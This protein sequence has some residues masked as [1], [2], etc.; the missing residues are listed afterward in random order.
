MLKQIISQLDKR[1][2]DVNNMSIHL[3]L[4]DDLNEI[5]NRDDIDSADYNYDLKNVINDV[6]QYRITNS[7]LLDYY[8]YI[9]NSDSVIAN[10]SLYSNDLF[11]KRV[12]NYNELSYDEW[13]ELLNKPY[14]GDI[15]EASTSKVLKD[16]TLVFDETNVV[17]YMRSIPI[18]FS[19]YAKGTVIVLVDEEDIQKYFNKIVNND[20]SWGYIADNNGNIITSVND[21]SKSFKIM[22]KNIEGNEGFIEDHSV[23]DN[24][25]VSYAVS[26]YNDWVYV[27]GVSTDV[28]MANL[29][30]IKK[31]TILIVVLDLLIGLII[32]M[33]FAY[34]NSKPVKK[35][36][37]MVKDFFDVNDKVDNLEDLSGSVLKLIDNNMILKESLNK[38][39]PILRQTF[40][41]RLLNSKFNNLDEIKAIMSYTGIK[42]EAQNYIVVIMHYYDNDELIDE[43]VVKEFDIVKLILKESINSLLGDKGLS[44]DID[45]RKIAL[46]IY[47][48]TDDEK[49]C[50]NNTK[51]IIDSICK[52][53]DNQYNIKLFFSIGSIYNDL[54]SL[55][56]SYKE[57]VEVM[58]IN[59][60]YK[61]N[62]LFYQEVKNDLKPYYFPIDI[63]VKLI[64]YV[65]AGRYQ[66]VNDI[67]DLMYDENFV[68]RHLHPN[69]LKIFINQLI[70]TLIRIENSLEIVVSDFDDLQSSGNNLD[71]IVAMDKRYKN[72]LKSYI[73]I[74]KI[75]DDKKSNKNKVL[76]KD[77][78]SFIKQNYNDPN[79]SLGAV[80]NHFNLT[81]GYLSHFIKDQIEV[82]FLSYIE[83]IRM[84]SA[85]DFLV[86]TEYSITE[87]SKMVGY[88]TPQA[89]RRAFKR[90]L[91]LTPKKYRE[92]EDII[93]NKIQIDKNI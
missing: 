31:T 52:E 17:V 86:N 61:N 88:N 3:G 35:T 10:R 75:I 72:I 62:I 79:I 58:H 38:Q 6:S 26:D 32:A 70:G 14:Y 77:I 16:G 22:D 29:L 5:L 49:V 67:F 48:Y 28:V 66:D 47:F 68:K 64:N 81:E 24:M 18:D 65:K 53:F 56:A 40:F 21:S 19:S 15:F 43:N 41:D 55:G 2:Q 8:I 13:N 74:S 59:K 90:N 51:M 63:E 83:N 30:H 20:Q 34:Y 80:A 78:I 45:E 46:V 93:N 76:I 23:G 89:F 1:F 54:L 9:K 11:Y 73:K 39:L 87:I 37:D 27:V 4:R 92:N 44:Y 82:N 50:I 57:A 7:F 69:Y 91:G 33:I 36:I 84:K 25:L 85:K 71:E 12:F 42:M 60:E